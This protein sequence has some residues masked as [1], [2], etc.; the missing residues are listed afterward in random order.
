MKYNKFM[1]LI[2]I[3]SLLLSPFFIIPA[4]RAAQSS[5]IIVHC[6]NPEGKE[7]NSIEGL[8]GNEVEIYD[9]DAFIG[10]GAHNSFTHCQPIPIAPGNHAIKVKFNGMTL[11][12]NITLESNTTRVLTFVFERRDWDFISILDSIGTVSQEIPF[13]EIVPY[14]TIWQN[15]DLRGEPPYPD[16]HLA[17]WLG[18]RNLQEDSTDILS[19]IFSCEMTISSTNMTVTDM[20]SFPTSQLELLGEEFYFEMSSHATDKTGVRYHSTI[21]EFLSDPPL[22]Q[23]WYIQY[24]P[25]P[26]I[27][28][29]AAIVTFDQEHYLTNSP[30]YDLLRI[31][32]NRLTQFY[33]TI[34]GSYGL[35]YYK[36]NYDF[37]EYNII[38][39]GVFTND[40]VYVIS[41]PSDIAGTAV[42][43]DNRLLFSGPAVDK[44]T[45]IAS[46][47]PKISCKV[48]ECANGAGVSAALVT[49]DV[50]NPNGTPE[51]I[52][53]AE[54][55]QEPG[56]Y[57]G[58]YPNTT[59]PGPH[60]II[61]RAEKQGYI[62]AE[63]AGLGFVV[64]APELG[65]PQDAA[66]A[67]GEDPINL[68]NGNLFSPHKDISIPGRGLSLEFIRTYNSRKPNT[69]LSGPLG[70][71]WNYNYAMSIT[72]NT[73]DSVTLMDEEGRLL[74]FSPLSPTS[75]QS[76]PGNHDR[77]TKEPD[78]TYILL[79]KHGRKL[80]FNNFGIPNLPLM[81]LAK[82][83]ERNGN[84]IN[85]SR[86]PQDTVISDSS[87][88][89]LSLIINAQR[90]VS[91]VRGPQDM[92]FKYEY[93]AS[94]NLIKAIDPLDKE[95]LYQYDENHNLIRI[96]DAK[97]HSTYFAHDE[98]DRCFGT[99]QDGHN[100]EVILAF[101]PEAR[102]TTVTD[103]LGNATRYEYDSS[104]LITKITDS[105]NNTQVFSWDEDLNKIS[106]TD[107]N[108]RT[109]AFSYDARG[110]L[111]TIN[112]PLNNL[113]AFTYE[114]DY[115]MVSSVTGPLG[116]TTAYTY[117]SKGNL[118]EV[119]DAL[120]NTTEYTYNAQGDLIRVKDANNNITNFTYDIH[121][122]LIQIV[123]A[124][125]NPASFTYDMVGNLIQTTDAKGNTTQFTYNLMNRLM[126]V[127]YPDNSRAVRIY[128]P[129]GN[130]VVFIDANNQITKY[131]YDVANRLIEITD[132]LGNITRYGYDTE[133]NRLSVT[134][135]NNVNTQYL[136]DS[137][138]R[139]IKAFDPL[140]KLTVFNYDPAGNLIS[141]TDGNGNTINYIYDAN[142]RLTQIVYPDA[143]T[144][145]F[146]Y[147]TLG[148]R[149]A[150]IDSSGTTVYS[151]DA[152]SHL[153]SVDGPQDKDTIAYAYDS[154]GNRTSL[155]DQDS[156]F[157]TYAYDDLNRLIRLTDSEGKVTT[158]SYNE[159]SNLTSMVYPNHTEA[160]YSFDR[161]NR[162]VELVNKSNKNKPAREKELSS[163]T[164]TYNPSGMRT[165]VILKNGSYIEYA[166]DALNRL[167]KEAGYNKHGYLG[168]V[169]E[170]TFDAAGNRL[171]LRKTP[172]RHLFWRDWVCH[173]EDGFRDN[174][175]MELDIREEDSESEQSQDGLDGSSCYH[176][177]KPKPSIFTKYTYNQ[178]NQLTLEEQGL[179]WKNRFILLTKTAYTYDANGNQLEK[180]ILKG[181]GRH[182]PEKTT[183][184][185]D[186]ENRL[187]KIAYPAFDKHKGWGSRHATSEYA[188][189]GLGRRIKAVEDEEITVYLYDGLN[190]II[191]RNE[192][193]KTTATHIRGLSYGGGIGSIISSTRKKPF[194]RDMPTAYYHYDGLGSV[195][196]LTSSQGH[197][198]INYEYDAYGNILK[199]TGLTSLNP[200]GFSTKEY[201]P[202]SGLIYFGARYYDPRVGRWI[203]K[204]PLGMVDGPNLYVFVRNNP[205]N[206]I[207]WLGFDAVVL[208]DSDGAWGF[209]HNAIAIGN[210]ST[211]WDYYSQDGPR[212]GGGHHIHYNSYEELMIAQSNRYDRSHRLTSTPEQDQRMRDSADANLHNPY[213]ANPFDSDRYHCAD[214][215]NDSLER[216]GISCGQESFGN[217]PNDAFNGI[218][219]INPLTVK[220][221]N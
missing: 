152:L 191:E 115:D 203:T 177:S 128:D 144:V 117:D 72:K 7:I 96:T 6:H 31:P 198:I 12:Q 219:Q 119:K 60:S 122:N 105:Q 209:G 14:D 134:D 57:T 179:E 118:I 201:S 77:L 112:G 149:T 184:T 107:Q 11:E 139:L 2:I 70:Y 130:L 41:V 132:A 81:L 200:Y 160:R 217:K 161:L 116:S 99:W 182:H 53:L 103:S 76:P 79:R 58:V 64:T 202:Q 147:D 188:Y 18:I 66:A 176:P 15:I 1:R 59:V 215:V 38:G 186:Y 71:G 111:L 216:G 61:L 156:K 50:V 3:L 206:F 22:F 187:T 143:S 39:T 125:N 194:G 73:D 80:Y 100:N 212:A 10:F 113:T 42:G 141:K 213:S 121:G 102:T 90:R 28:G 146:I 27:G 32:I 47:E 169:N 45:Y 150:M 171:T 92:V 67:V 145:S 109:T 43:D 34:Q 136:Y 211:G 123:D 214:L 183:Y 189:D 24:A 172:P 195:T 106:S 33:V 48:I 170:Y 196:N 5:Y 23:E 49:A 95:T 55:T 131:S 63:A 178:A 158:Y 82:I 114:P 140:G 133:G 173:F 110:N 108:G 51:T 26:D 87:G 154:V 120:N 199:Q 9:G 29:K 126:Q 94:G 86:T 69:L 174:L 89:S 30:V 93:D 205:L 101:A 78:G 166:Y 97:G 19:G 104:G 124:L 159:L 40:K 85:I 197:A 221:E 164:Y 17:D 98:K 35:Y 54:S 208:N 74:T 165:R 127:I 167:T 75:Y 16:I 138:N 204:D 84:T 88:R 46:E 192:D 44:T 153:T 68:T 163:Y 36:T 20:L 13:Y 25:T 175:K 168:Y 155:T 137:L 129:V 37:R 91:E 83:E 157:T 135:A 62:S 162:L 52:P 180:I 148:R 218:R 207:D 151:Y 142:N 21:F 220:G 65:T 4:A 210:D 8:W 190:P 56:T 185:Y 181:H 193:G